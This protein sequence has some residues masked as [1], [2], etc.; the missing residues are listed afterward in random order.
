[1]QRMGGKL[2]PRGNCDYD[3]IEELDGDEDELSC[4]SF[5]SQGSVLAVGD[6]AG[7]IATFNLDTTGLTR[8]KTLPYAKLEYFFEFQPFA[9]EYDHVDSN[10]VPEQ[11]KCIAWVNSSSSRHTM[12]AA[13]NKVI[14]LC[15]VYKD[16]IDPIYFVS[17][18]KLSAI[19]ELSE[20]SKLVVPPRASRPDWNARI[21]AEYTTGHRFNIHTCK[22]C[23]DHSNFITADHVK[24]NY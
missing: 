18:N 10:F 19:E 3:M 16:A 5:N 11:V 20:N 4:Q 12:L 6:K 15:K 9:P 2:D 13:N 7:R 23:A 21:E 14:K 22:L 24:V 1:M 8:S 17:E